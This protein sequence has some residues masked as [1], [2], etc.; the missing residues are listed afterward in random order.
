MSWFRKP[1]MHPALPRLLSRDLCIPWW[2]PP[3]AGLCDSRGMSGNTGC[4]VLRSCK[5]LRYS[6]GCGGDA[7]SNWRKICAERKKSDGVRESLASKEC[8]FT[9]WLGRSPGG[10][11]PTLQCSLRKSHEQRPCILRIKRSKGLE[12]TKHNEPTLKAEIT[13]PS[14]MYLGSHIAVESRTSDSHQ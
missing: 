9:P 5:A 6:R 3:L 12:P 4:W 8:G 11:G 2:P 7:W 1:T 13:F 10:N 14:S